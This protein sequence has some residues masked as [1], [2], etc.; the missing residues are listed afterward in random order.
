[1]FHCNRTLGIHTFELQCDL[2]FEEYQH[3][4]ETLYHLSKEASKRFFPQKNFQKCELYS[5][6]GLSIFF[7]PRQIKIIVNP[8]RLIDPEDVIGLYAPDLCY[9]P[10]AEM[11]FLLISFFETFLTDE[12][13]SRLF[14]KRMDYTIDAFLPS[15]EHVLL[16]I[17]LAKKN[18]LPRGFQETYPA[19][20]RNSPDFNEKFS[21]DV[22]H[23]SGTYHVTLYAKHQQLYGR[24]NIPQDTLDNTKGLLRTEISCIYPKN[25]FPS[26]YDEELESLFHSANLMSVYQDTI[27]KLFPYGSYLKSPL[28]KEILEARY[29]NKRALKKHILEYLDNNITYHSFHNGYKLMKDKNIPRKTLLEAFYNAGVNPVTIAVNDKISRLPS[30]YSILGLLNPYQE[31]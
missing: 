8:S 15:E 17:K 16:Y 28:A 18:G 26:I 12:I 31:F 13:V 4:R 2:H 29:K 3:V 7:N 6:Q 14:V 25:I 30:I 21:Y 22:S 10:V 9:V 20:V 1:M 24:K 5:D 27:P 23:S 19:H 11:F